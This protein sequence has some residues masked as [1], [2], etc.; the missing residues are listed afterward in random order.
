MHARAMAQM[1]ATLLALIGCGSEV[2]REPGGEGGDGGTA[3]V[4]GSGSESTGGG[5]ST[6]GSFSSNASA[7]SGACTA[8]TE[9]A[10][11]FEC[12]LGTCTEGCFGGSPCGDNC[13]PGSVCVPCTDPLCP[14]CPPC[15]SECL[16]TDPEHCDP[17]DPCPPGAV[18]SWFTR[19]CLP[20]CEADGNC[21]APDQVCEP[22]ATSSCCGCENCVPGCIEVD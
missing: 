5:P 17:D 13:G 16:P 6:T 4:V 20:A 19:A 3:G 22:C 10:F 11:G 12:Y 9:C 18:C 15:L 8:S 21:A 14:D 1:A 7:G 2:I